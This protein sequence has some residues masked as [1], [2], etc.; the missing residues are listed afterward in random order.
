[1]GYTI[2]YWTAALLSTI[3]TEW[4]NSPPHLQFN[5]YVLKGY[6]PVSSA[7]DCVRSLFYLHNELGN[8]Y[9]HG[10]PL[11]CFM[12]LLPFSIPWSQISIT[13]L[14]VVHILACLSPHIGS[15][16][17]HLFMNHEGGAPVYHTL[18]ALDMCGIC[19]INTL[20]ALHIVYITLLCYPSIR[21]A[22]LLAYILLSV[23]GIYSAV[24]ARDSMR[25]LRSFVW[26]ALFRLTLFL[27]RRLGVGVGSP[28]SLRH[29]IAMDTLAVL[30]GVINISR[31]PERLRPGLFDYWLNSHQIM[32]V[33]VVGA[34][35]CLHWGV[36]DDLV[37][38]NGYLCPSD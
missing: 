8:I 21:S 36:V 17:Y 32:H 37:W 16:L 6:R 20:G 30:G 35:V 1:M 29:F 14:A 3:N 23:Y 2:G 11:L 19:M 34:I 7:Q 4:A 27:L 22:A 31:F 13:W 33:L 10:I 18:L 28:S 38:I 15:V 9:T 26:Q 5:K 25:R 12:V 24:T